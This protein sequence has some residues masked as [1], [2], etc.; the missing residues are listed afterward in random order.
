MLLEIKDLQKDYK[1]FSLQCSLSIPKGRITG[2]VGQNG[3]GKS[4]LFKAI[5]NLISLDSGQIQIFKTSADSLSSSDREKIGVVFSDSGFSGYLTVTDVIAIMRASYSSFKKEEFLS[6]CKHFSIPLKKKI[7]DFSTG[8]KAKL[9]LL[10]A[11]SYDA[12]FLILDEPTLGLDVVARKELLDLLRS[13]METE[14]RSIIISS[15]IAS[16]LETLCDDL[17][18]LHN[19]EIYLHEDTDVLLDEYGVL[20]ITKE[21]YASLDKTYLLSVKEETFGCECLTNQRQYYAENYPDIIIEKSHIDDILT[22]TILGKQLTNPGSRNNLSPENS[23]G[24]ADR[25]K[26]VL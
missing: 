5:L 23:N 4:T 25:Y 11:M 19:G 14:N 10:L 18:L 2:I 22:L 8:M 16:D 12:D 15:H 3:A 1:D 7:K 26:E 13:Y 9:K 20:K 24:T 6:H 17:Y 21:Q